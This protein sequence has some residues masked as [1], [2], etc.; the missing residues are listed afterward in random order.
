MLDDV[1]SNRSHSRQKSC[2]S[3]PHSSNITERPCVPCGATCWS[4]H[5]S[6]YNTISYYYLCSQQIFFS[7]FEA[8]IINY[9]KTYHIN[10]C[11]EH[12]PTGTYLLIK[13]NIYINTIVEEK[14][15]SFDRLQKLWK[16]QVRD[17]V[18]ARA[19]TWLPRGFKRRQPNTVHYFH[20]STPPPHS[21]SH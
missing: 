15:Y 12:E 9:K 7:F 4:N 18:V 1:S 6:S 16:L 3:H 5:A 19:A 13:K 2:F 20:I 17:S 14:N 11:P 8:S 21:L 10:H